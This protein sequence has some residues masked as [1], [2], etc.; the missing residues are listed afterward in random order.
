MVEEGV[1]E[2]EGLICGNFINEVR[3]PIN[4]T[5]DELSKIIADPVI[6]DLELYLV[7]SDIRKLCGLDCD[8][9]TLRESLGDEIGRCYKV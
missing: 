5:D 7:V 6:V 3:G 8:S 2:L 1:V 9:G 4:D